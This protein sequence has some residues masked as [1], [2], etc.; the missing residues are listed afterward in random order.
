MG[1][2]LEGNGSGAAAGHQRH[3]QPELLQVPDQRC[4]AGDRRGRGQQRFS[5]RLTHCQQ[6][7]DAGRRHSRRLHPMAHLLGTVEPAAPPQGQQLL[8]GKPQPEV[9]GCQL[10]GAGMQRL[11]I[12]QQPIEIKQA[13]GRHAHRVILSAGGS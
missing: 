6:R 3:G 5:D 1:S 2:R 10:P 8:G 11:G 13:G 9:L 12:E 7:L 4:R